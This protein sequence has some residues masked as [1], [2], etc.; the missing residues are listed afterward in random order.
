MPVGWLAVQVITAPDVGEDSVTSADICPE[1]MVCVGGD[2]N[3]V[4]AGFTV[5]IKL[6]G[7]PLQVPNFGVTVTVPEIGLL[8]LFVAAKAAI[9][10]VPFAAKPIAVLLFA[11]V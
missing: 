6:S 3:T 9:F 5:I 7:V 10:P 4:G 1:Q 11:Q 2:I 8:V